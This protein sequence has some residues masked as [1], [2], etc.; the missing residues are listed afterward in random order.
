[1]DLGVLLSGYD[2]AMVGEGL[3]FERGSV[4]GIVNGVALVLDA[5]FGG[6]V[7]EVCQ[8]V[9]VEVEVYVIVVV[10]CFGSGFWDEV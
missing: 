9:V 7:V 4:S 1:M 3:W 8:G 2:E 6:V 10:F 5:F